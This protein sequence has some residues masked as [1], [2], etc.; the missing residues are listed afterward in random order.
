VQ[1]LAD[2]ERLKQKISDSGMTIKAVA[3]H[4]DIKRHTLD[5]R[6]KGEGEFTA[7]E[8]VGLT[9]ALRMNVSERNEIF[10]R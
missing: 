3:E 5:R 10:L 9:K 7:S 2:L 1:T 6:L 8:I 4:A